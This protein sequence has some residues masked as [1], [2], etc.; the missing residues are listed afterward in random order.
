MSTEQKQS[1][2]EASES[3]IKHEVS[4]LTRSSSVV[5]YTRRELEDMERRLSLAS[6]GEHGFDLGSLIVV[7]LCTY[8]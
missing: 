7:P 3:E 2:G 6:Q 5:V 1:K 8:V 4:K